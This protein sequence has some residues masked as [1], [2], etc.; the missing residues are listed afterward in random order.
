MVTSDFLT[1]TVLEWLQTLDYEYM[2]LHI[3][4]CYGLY[5]SENMKWIVAYFSPVRKKGVSKAVWLIG[6]FL[7]ALEIFR[8]LPYI[9]EGGLSTQKIISI[10]HSYIVIQVFVEPIV[11]TVNKWLNV[12]RKTTSG[13]S[14]TTKGD[15]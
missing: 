11:S 6:L 1:D 4:V 13:M 14:G 15:Q 7:M 10:I 12:F 8:F 9:G 2:V 5:Y 3:I